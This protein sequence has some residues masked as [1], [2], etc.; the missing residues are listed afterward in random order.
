MGI[1][2]RFRDII[3]SN[4]NAMLDRA[5]DPDKLIK[6]MINEMEDTL[7]ELKAACADV[8]ANR[9][10]IQRRLDDITGREKLWR[11]RSELAVNKGRDDLA[12]EALIEKKRFVQMHQTLEVELA[13]HSELLDQYYSD[14]N[15][16]EE[17]LRKAKEKQHMLVQR[18]LH[19]RRSKEAQLE[20]RRMDNFETIAKFDEL[21]GRIDRMEA[22]V[23]LVNPMSKSSL[24][25]Q[26]NE[27][28][29]DEEVEKELAAL[30][31][32]Q[33]D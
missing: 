27:L 8:I 30:K 10:K 28:D 22:E 20:I 9:K 17:K 33:K 12:R 24:E 29:V 32:S 11:D 4:I 3:S 2:T 25:T 23:D 7:V 15:Q 26:F 21:E 14:I 18:H 16:L 1:Y 13:L 5:E 19:A 6:M 31:A